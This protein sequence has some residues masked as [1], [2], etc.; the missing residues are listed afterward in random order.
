MA[1]GRKCPQCRFPMYA[2][3]EQDQPKGR[4]VTYVCQ[5]NACANYVK[6]NGRYRFEER[7]FESF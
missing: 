6:T 5:S 3:K 4:Y 1:K 2:A 7:V